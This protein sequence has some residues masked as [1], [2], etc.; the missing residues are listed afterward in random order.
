MVHIMIYE[1]EYVVLLNL[2]F[3][4]AEKGICVGYSKATEFMA[5][6]NHV[7][8]YLLVL[9]ISHFIHNKF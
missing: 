1:S 7:R 3:F 4:D 2:K 6:L 9:Y 8:S 5:V